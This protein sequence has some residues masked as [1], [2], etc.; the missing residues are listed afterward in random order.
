MSSPRL[1]LGARRGE[2]R[3]LRG[4][5]ASNHEI[6]LRIVPRPFPTEIR[7]SPVDA[8]NRVTHGAKAWSISA[9]PRRLR[10]SL[11]V[12]LL[13]A[14]CSSSP[15]AST[16]GVP[17]APGSPWPK[18]R[19][20][21]AQT[22]RSAVHATRSRA[23]PS[24]SSRPGKG[25]FS[26]PIV[27]ADGTIYFGSA[28]QNFYALDAGRLDAVDDPH[29]RDHRL[30]RVCSTTAGRVYFGS[31][32][33]I[34]RAADAQTGQIVWTIAGRLPRRPR[35]ASSTGSR[36]TSP[37]AA[38]GTLYVPNDNFLV[39]AVDR[40]KR[41][42]RTGRT[43]C[44]TRPGRCP[45]STR[46]RARSTSATTTCSPS[47]ARTP[48]A[49]APDG[50]TNWSMVVARHR[51]GEPAA[52]AGR[53]RRRR[54]VRRLR[55]RLRRGRRDGRSGS[56]RRATTSTRAP[57]SFPTAPS[58]SRRP[59]ARSTRV[60]PD[61]GQPAL[62]ASTPARPSARRPRSTPTGTSTSAA[63]TAT[64]TCST[65]TARCASR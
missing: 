59:T 39:Y 15:G 62:D 29:R 2:V 45:R 21:A 33:G 55:A 22:A 16:P 6:E 5:P 27:G 40:D 4:T 19:G 23:A 31:G 20:N 11:L 48:S 10:S 47:S 52:H 37:S 60:S 26:S 61:D 56:S 25:I 42:R 50:T 17:V 32:D 14:G 46:R 58:S 34:L 41:H 44:P 1:W 49:I 43:R 8:G 28:D 30:V 24:G 18:F 54:R 9:M 13:V 51:R 38:D 35:A 12:A 7:G 63:A 64:S 36:A 57:R 53:R 3:G 65:P